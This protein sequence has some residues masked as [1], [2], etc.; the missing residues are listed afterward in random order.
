MITMSVAKVGPD[1]AERARAYVDGIDKELSR[2]AALLAG[3]T[4]RQITDNKQIASGLTWKSIVGGVDDLE[5]G[6]RTMW[7]GGI[8]TFKWLREGRGPGKFPPVS[9]IIEWIK[10][11]GVTPPQADRLTSADVKRAVRK[12][13]SIYNG[14]IGPLTPAAAEKAR[15]AYER[16]VAQ[17]SKRDQHQTK[18]Q[19]IEAF[20]YAIAW[21]IAHHGTK[22]WRGETPDP[23]AKAIKVRHEAMLAALHGVLYGKGRS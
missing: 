5:D 18:E 17:V 2:Q 12:A 19:A 7:V 13:T 4:Q 16:R 1:L 15:K 21:G 8:K 23:L 6:T 10:R 22:R 3:E 11:K 9:A 20:A 14:R